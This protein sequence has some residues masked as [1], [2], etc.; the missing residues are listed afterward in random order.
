[1]TKGDASPAESASRW[2]LLLLLSCGLC[3]LVVEGAVSLI[4]SIQVQNPAFM[5]AWPVFTYGRMA[6][7]TETTFVYG[8]LANTG[9]ALTL[10]VLGRLAGEPL[11]GRNWAIGG[12]IFWNLAVAGA[13]AGVAL[14]GATGFELLGLPGYVQSILFFSYAAIAVPGLVAW[15]GRLRGTSFASHWYSAAALFL[16]PWVLSTAHVMLFYA[17]GRGV[18]QPIVAAWYAQSAWSLWLAPMALSVAYYVVPKV[19]RRVLPSYRF[20]PLGFWCLILV[21]GLTGGRHL[22]GGP[23]PVWISSVAVVSCT[24]LLFHVFV[25]LLNLRGSY[26]V[27]GIAAKFIAF[28]L[29]CYAVG[30][31]S[32]ALTS[33]RGIAL[34]TQF[35]YLGE[36]QK[37][38]AL[39]GA[40]SGLLFGGFYFA[41]PRITGRGWSSGNLVRAHLFLFVAGILLLVGSLCTAA[42]VQSR[43]LLDASVP[44]ATI[45]R[46][47]HLPLVCA[48]AAQALIFLG[49]IAFLVNFLRTTC[50]IPRVSA[51]ASPEKVPAAESRSP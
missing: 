2:P 27:P 9:L 18:L 48:A 19:T 14:G 21:G 24:F 50:W 51:P 37:L 5:A 26:A 6:E 13:L 34:H 15:S 39:C 29:A 42:A 35:T 1:M 33:F 23:V 16:F 49:S 43:G 38:L 11:R 20:A 8:W 28:G 36:A 47:T 10:W 4:A 40:A 17:P 31:L 32:D 30:A 41:V 44:F 25:V 46:K 45:T 22:L 7:A 12:A 3:W